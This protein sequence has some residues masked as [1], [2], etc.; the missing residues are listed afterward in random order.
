MRTG[1]LLEHV[2]H[3][4]E[5]LGRE[6]AVDGAAGAVTAQGARAAHH[7]G[8]DLG[9]GVLPDGRAEVCGLYAFCFV[10]SRFVFCLCAGKR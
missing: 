2:D 9:Q 5:A 8:V 3:F 10:F 4:R 7:G 6:L 1:A